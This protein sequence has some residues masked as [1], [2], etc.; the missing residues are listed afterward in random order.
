MEICKHHFKQKYVYW[1]HH[2]Y[3]CSTDKCQK[4]KM[5]RIYV[6][7]CVLWDI[8]I[9][10][11]LD[12]I[13]HVGI[14]LQNWMT[15]HSHNHKSYIV[16]AFMIFFFFLFKFVIR[17]PMNVCTCSFSFSFD[18][19]FDSAPTS[20]DRIDSLYR[21]IAILVYKI[22]YEQHIIKIYT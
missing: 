6:S 19:L 3:I 14:H 7:V 10:H 13:H 5:I 4:W 11:I 21:C 1:N 12:S 8:G 22:A 17:I 2:I 9:Y 18:F 20:S 16:H 15:T